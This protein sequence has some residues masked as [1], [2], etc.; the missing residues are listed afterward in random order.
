MMIKLEMPEKIV[1][2]RLTMERLRREDAEEI[3]YSYASK[4]E[5]TKYASWPT[6]QSIDQ[7]R[8]FLRYADEAWGLGLDFSYGLRIAPT[9][10]FI[11]S[12]GALHENG[13]IQF[14]YVIS[15]SEWG[16]GYAT[17]AC[18]TMMKL[19]GSM[20][21]LYRIGTFV[22][23]ENIASIRVLQ[24]CGLVE[25]ARLPRWFRFVNQDDR[26]KDCVLFRLDTK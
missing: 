12:F 11:G 25:E 14:G 8:D 23:A 3:F 17:E 16:Q 4:P 1:T 18:A 24:K 13:K 5:A 15:P 21:S 22:D 2:E 26:P 10:K 9:G 19:F 6:H 7:T 20:P